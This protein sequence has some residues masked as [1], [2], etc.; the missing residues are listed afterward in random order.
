MPRTTPPNY[1]DISSKI[2]IET[3]WHNSEELNNFHDKNAESVHDLDSD[4][5]MSANWFE[6]LSNCYYNKELEEE[7]SPE[8]KESESGESWPITDYRN[9]DD[10]SQ[11]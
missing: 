11:L 3:D 4:T 2:I 9:I 1:D 5:I 6:T 8:S 10:L 7:G